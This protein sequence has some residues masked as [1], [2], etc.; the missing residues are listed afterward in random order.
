MSLDNGG[1]IGNENG[2]KDSFE[3]EVIEPTAMENEYYFEGK[4]KINS[5]QK[6]LKK[7]R[8]K[9]SPPKK[10]TEDYCSYCLGF[11]RSKNVSYILLNSF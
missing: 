5:K 6:N 7:K 3:K 8:A 10:R 1:F 9:K 2:P 11:F 4:L